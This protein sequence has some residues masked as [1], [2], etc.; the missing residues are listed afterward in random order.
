[1]AQKAD[2][3]FSL[4][5]QQNH[6]LLRIGTIACQ[7]IIAYN[8]RFRYRIA[9]ARVSA[10]FVF[11]TFRCNRCTVCCC[12]SWFNEHFLRTH[13]HTA[14]KNEKYHGN[15]NMQNYWIYSNV[16]WIRSNIHLYRMKILLEYIFWPPSTKKNTQRNSTMYKT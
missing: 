8:S 4:E 12:C 6:L 13:T 7:N 2:Y 15:K 11:I 16:E 14:K 9:G 1:M 10:L 5:Q 3:L